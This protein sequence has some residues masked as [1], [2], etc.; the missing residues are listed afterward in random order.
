MLERI[1]WRKLPKSFQDAFLIAARLGIR[2]LWI[3]SLCILQSG[4]GYKQDWEE[5]VHDMQLVYLNGFLNIS[6][7]RAHNPHQ[8]AFTTRTKRISDQLQS[9]YILR[10]LGKEPQQMWQVYDEQSEGFSTLMK[11]PL[12]QRA[13]VFQERLLSPRVLHYGE[14]IT[15]ECNTSKMLSESLPEGCQLDQH[16]AFPFSIPVPLRTRAGRMSQRDELLSTWRFTVL[17]YSRRSLSFPSKDKLAAF[18]GVAQRFGAFYDDYVAGFFRCHLPHQLAWSFHSPTTRP[19]DSQYRAPTWSWASVDG[20]IELPAVDISASVVYA[21]VKTLNVDLVDGSNKYGP[22]RYADINLRCIVIPCHLQKHLADHTI[23]YCHIVF[24]SQDEHLSRL[25]RSLE[26]TPICTVDDPSY[27]LVEEET[28]LVPI[29]SSG[30]GYFHG[31][32]LRRTEG[33]STFKRVGSYQLWL[34]SSEFIETFQKIR[35]V[36]EQIT[37]V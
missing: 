37:I 7:D 36:Y 13:W 1:P 32:L 22:L 9:C 26:K 10:N 33:M 24:Q 4:P 34:N 28:F 30:Y 35:H 18:A 16:F 25:F 2:Y 27:L 11:D 23:P 12:Q 20:S 21:Q 3:D 8:G 19:G 14:Q 6:L 31:I 5:H 29:Y 17:D 15:W